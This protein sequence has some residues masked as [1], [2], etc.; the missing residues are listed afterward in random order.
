[1]PPPVPLIPPDPSNPAEI[2]PASPP[3]SSAPSPVTSQD[4]PPPSFSE[5]TPEIPSSSPQATGQGVLGNAPAGATPYSELPKEQKCGEAHPS[6]TVPP[7]STESPSPKSPADSTFSWA[8]FGASTCKIPQSDVHVN[9]SPEGR[10]RVKI[11]NS[12]FERGAKLHSDY[13]VGVFYGKPLAYGKIWAVLNFLWGKDRKVTIQNLTKNAFLFYIPNPALRKR[14]LQHE[15]WR[16]G[17][18]PFFVTPWKAEYSF[19][20][21]ALDRAPVWAKISNIPCD[22]VTDEGLSFIV[23][24]LGKVVDAKPFTIYNSAEV[25]VVVDLTKP[26]PSELEIEREDGNIVVLQVKFP[27]LPPVCPVCNEIGHKA[28]FCPTVESPRNQTK[29]PT[30]NKGKGK[31]GEEASKSAPPQ[32]KKKSSASSEDKASSSEVPRTKSAP[33][34]SKKPDIP[35]WVPK[36]KSGP[37]SMLDSTPDQSPTDPPASAS[38]DLPQSPTINTNPPFNATKKPSSPKKTPKP[39]PPTSSNLVKN[40]FEPLLLCDENQTSSMEIVIFSPNKDHFSPSSSAPKLS[41]KKRKLNDKF[42]PD[43]GGGFPLIT[44][45]SHQHL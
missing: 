8:Q 32:E 44:W 31:V 14:V 10:P 33:S 21:P 24:P 4:A 26:L 30:V 1:M 6:N 41:K 15:L 38:H 35:Q 39:S 29:P 7:V 43:K 28:Q 27:W 9:I 16:V 5:S 19:N 37:N 12:V 18:S 2:P 13:I 34:V 17:D 22:L 25:K 40:R 42:S 3:L 36:E 11:P 20:P 45:E 23:K